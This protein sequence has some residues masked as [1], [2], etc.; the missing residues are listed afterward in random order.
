[1]SLDLC[2]WQ[3]KVWEKF[4]TESGVTSWRFIRN[5]VKGDSDLIPPWKD[6]WAHFST[7]SDMQA[8]ETPKTCPSTPVI[9]KRTATPSFLFF[10]KLLES[11]CFTGIRVSWIRVISECKGLVIGVRA[12]AMKP[13]EP[14]GIPPSR[15]VPQTPMAC[16]TTQ[17]PGE[18][19][20]PI[21]PNPTPT[22]STVTLLSFRSCSLKNG[23]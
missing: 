10:S 23:L 6:G 11:L 14:A 8:P 5:A 18:M 3:G 4:F 9:D 16:P 12:G 2:T 17:I 19:P 13:P 7:W 1:M 21:T 15:R 20:I 22:S